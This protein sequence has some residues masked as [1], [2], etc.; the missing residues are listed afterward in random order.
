MSLFRYKGFYGSAQASIEDHCLFGKLEFIEPL[1]SYEG[2]DIEE[3]EQA[4]RAAVDD[5]LLDCEHLGREPAKPCKGSF[6]VRIGPELH[7]HAL[8]AAKENNLNLNEFVKRSLEA[9]IR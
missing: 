9:A 4:F 2:H 5:Y 7:R 1:V 8:I 3:L 6:N